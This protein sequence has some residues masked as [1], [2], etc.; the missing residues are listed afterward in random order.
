MRVLSIVVAVLVAAGLAGAG[1]DGVRV[2]EDAGKWES[3]YGVEFYNVVGAIEVTD[4][5]PRKFVKL[6]VEALDAAGAVVATESAWN[7][8]A[9][10]LSA[11]D[12]DAAALVAAG[13][14][15]PVLPGKRQRFRTSFLKEEHPTI[16]KH[17][18]SVAEAPAAE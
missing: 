6:T 15:T 18:T 17:R 10:A 11:P 14:V 7:E 8:T 12:A 2:V 1:A 9:E 5:A 4:G 16:A 13:K 3:G